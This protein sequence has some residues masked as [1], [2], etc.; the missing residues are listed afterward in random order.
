MVTKMGYFTEVNKIHFKLGL[1]NYINQPYSPQ[2][3]HFFLA[4]FCLL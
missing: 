2:L 4:Q 1:Q 3:I